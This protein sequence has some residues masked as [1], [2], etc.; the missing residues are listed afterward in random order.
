MHCCVM[1]RSPS[2]VSL[3]RKLAAY[4][5]IRQ[6]EEEKTAE[7]LAEST[8][9]GSDAA[10]TAGLTAGGSTSLGGATSVTV[11]HT[12]EELQKR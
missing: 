4:F 9:M 1:L 2:L 10:T 12:A 6:T 8:G 5:V 3:Q 11:V 7:Q